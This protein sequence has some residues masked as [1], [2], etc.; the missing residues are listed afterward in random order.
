MAQFAGV[1]VIG[2][3]VAGCSTAY[4][5]AKSGIN[6]TLIEGDAVTSKVLGMSGAC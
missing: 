3:G 4:Y 2:G 5:L 1:V 6:C